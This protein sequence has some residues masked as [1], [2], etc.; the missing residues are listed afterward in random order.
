[1]KIVSSA[2]NALLIVVF[3]HSAEHF[4]MKLTTLPVKSMGTDVRKKNKDTKLRK[5]SF[6]AVFYA[7]ILVLTDKN[8][9]DCV[10]MFEK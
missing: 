4:S 5:Q 6:Y 3:S 8:L 2:T 10:T 9:G 7:S 1:M